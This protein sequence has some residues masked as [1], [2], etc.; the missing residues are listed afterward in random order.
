MERRP[1]PVSE[2]KYF[3]KIAIDRVEWKRLQETF[4][5]FGP[6]IL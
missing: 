5:Y 3:Q 2:N 6:R 4:A 1:E